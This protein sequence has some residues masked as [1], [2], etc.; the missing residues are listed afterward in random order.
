MDNPLALFSKIKCFVLDIDGVLTNGELLVTSDGDLLRTMNIRDGYAM[1][2]AIKKDYH[3]WIISGGKQNAPALRLQKLGIKEVHLNVENKKD[4]L[5]DLLSLYHIDASQVLY[6]GD[7]IPDY[8][9]M[10]YC[11][12]G[13][14]PADAAEEI[15]S[16]AQ[17][18]SP[19]VGGRGCVRD[20]I[21]KV[22]KLNGDWDI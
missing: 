12:L 17:Y 16:I 20:V 19:I 11:G 7:D 14:C 5:L 9:I 18:I 8:H 13:T 1:A 3:I 21:E 2:I 15:K 10:Q 22:L 4:K 6:M